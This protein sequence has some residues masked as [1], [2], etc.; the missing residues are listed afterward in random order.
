MILSRV[1]LSHV[2][3]AKSSFFSSKCQYLSRSNYPHNG[4]KLKMSAIALL[5]HFSFLHF[6]LIAL[7]PPHISPKLNSLL[8]HL[9]K[10][11]STMDNSG[12][13]PPSP[14]LSNYFI[15]A[16]T[17]FCNNAFHTLIGLNLQNAYGPYVSS[18]KTVLPCLYC[19]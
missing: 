4:T 12:L 11:N 3:L 6:N 9:L 7:L 5:L 14:P 10:K 13:V 16:I 15:L 18:F 2:Q 8:K 19:T 17:I 1:M